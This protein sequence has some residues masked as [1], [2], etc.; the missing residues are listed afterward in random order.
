LILFVAGFAHPPNVDAAVWL[1]NEIMPLVR[2]DVP[3][4]SLRLVGSN[5]TAFVKNLASHFTQVTGYVPSGELAAM[6][7]DARVSVVPLRFGAGV[8]LKAVEALH[9]GLPLVTTPTGAQGLEGL[10]DVVP[11]VDDAK[12]IAAAIVQLLSDDA[13][14]S[15]QA[16][17][18]L[19]Y[20]K[21]RFS[22]QASIAAISEA[23]K[24][25]TEHAEKR[26]RATRAPRKEMSQQGAAVV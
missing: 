10:K 22:R 20:A 1:V 2:R 7:S 6:Y 26:T 3:D 17:R 11:V 16:Q 18:Q 5:P 14:W 8:K 9:E 23:V 21:A 19:D 15:D 12:A 25:A 24:A 4:A 13:K